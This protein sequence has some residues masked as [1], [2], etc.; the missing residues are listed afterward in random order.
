MHPITLHMQ[1]AE[2]QIQKEE[3]CSWRRGLY[4]S[5]A[6]PVDHQELQTTVL[7]IISWK[8]FWG[9]TECILEKKKKK[10]I[11]CSV[12]LINLNDM[13][14]K[15]NFFSFLS[16]SVL[17]IKHTYEI[18]SPAPHEAI[19]ELEDNSRHHSQLWKWVGQREKNLCNLHF[20]LISIQ[21]PSKIYTSYISL[22]S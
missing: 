11:I 8:Q 22:A 12:Q 7:L 15:V 1:W 21:K 9:E 2:S 14:S 18:S 19:E 10:K 17:H 4:F 5:S 20:I 13:V 3:K 6:F 16:G